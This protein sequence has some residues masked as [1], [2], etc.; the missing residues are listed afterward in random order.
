VHPEV[1]K[2]G[3]TGVPA[4]ADSWLR[5][6]SSNAR[7]SRDT[8]DLYTLEIWLMNLGFAALTADKLDEPKPLLAEA[9]RI[10]F[11]IDD[12]VAQFYLVGAL[13]CQAATSGEHRLAAQLFGAS[14]NLRAQTGATVNAILAPC[15][16]RPPSAPELR[17]ASRSSTQNSPQAPVTAGT[18]RSGLLSASRPIAASKLL[19]T[20]GQLLLPSGKQRSHG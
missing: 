4:F 18:L 8:G 19:T 6:T 1:L 15:W 2:D 13:G 9:L 12:R 3:D 14:E 20:A 16:R 7:L 11:Q 10:A 5:V 17:S